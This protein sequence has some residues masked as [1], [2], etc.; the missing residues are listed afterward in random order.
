MALT[1][2]ATAFLATISDGDGADIAV[3][4]VYPG[5]DAFQTHAH[6]YFNNAATLC[7]GTHAHDFAI[8]GA[9]YCIRHG[10]ELWLKWITQKQIL[11]RVL[12]AIHSE[13]DLDAILVVAQDGCTGKQ[14]AARKEQLIHALCVLRNVE[15]GI[16]YPVCHEIDIS[17]DFARKCLSSVEV[18]EHRL[19][20]VWPISVH[21][22]DLRA[23][24]TE[25]SGF[26]EEGYPVAR[27]EASYTGV[28]VPVHPDTIAA[29]CELLSTWDPTGDGFRYP[30]SLSG[31][32][33]LELPPLNLAQLGNF[34]ESMES[35]VL[36]YEQD[37]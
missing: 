11:S 30:C 27:S 26:I 28:G 24:W 1:E 29:A 22:H 8:F 36:A 20:L 33:Y 3:P 37:T 12:D 32:W 4:S 2:G 16:V 9:L 17:E 18:N 10:L 7:R 15:E 21:G 13:A 19:A 6:A 14:K 31:D 23:L 35:T 34:A 5:I 25:A